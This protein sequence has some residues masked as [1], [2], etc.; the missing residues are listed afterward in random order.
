[1]ATVSSNTLEVVVKST[2]AQAVAAQMRQVTTATKELGERVKSVSST[3]AGM[4]GG[5]AAGYLSGKSLLGFAEKAEEAAKSVRQFETALKSTGQSGAVAVL[6]GQAS[7]LSAEMKQSAGSI[8]EVQKVLLELGLQAQTVAKYTPAVLDVA[9]GLG[10]DPATVAAQ[11]GRALSG[12]LGGLS[13]LG[14][15]A[16]TIKELD[17][18]LTR[19]EG[20]AKASATATDALNLAMGKIG[21]TLGD[22]INEGGLD[23]FKGKLAEGLEAVGKSLKKYLAEHKAFIEWLREMGGSL[24]EKAA[25]NLGK[26]ALALAAVSVSITALTAGGALI[27]LAQFYASLPLV[28][29]SL[30]LLTAGGRTFLTVFS[31]MAAVVGPG[32][33]AN[34]KAVTV[35]VGALRVALVGLGSAVAAVAVAW[36]GWNIGKKISEFKVAGVEIA[37]W[38][39]DTHLRSR[40]FWAHFFGFISDKAYEERK[41]RLK[42]QFDGLKELVKEGAEGVA[43]AVAEPTELGRVLITG[44][45]REFEDVMQDMQRMEIAYGRQMLAA[46]NLGD[47]TRAT[48]DALDDRIGKLTE[49]EEL[50][51]RDMALAQEAF[52][53]RR[54]MQRT[55]ESAEAFRE[56]DR[57]AI[58]AFYEAEKKFAERML[59]L[60]GDRLK[61]E[62]DRA[63]LRRE[64]AN[65]TYAGSTAE[66]FKAFGREK[67]AEGIAGTGGVGPGALAGVQNSMIQ[68]GT[69]ASQVGNAIQSSIGGVVNSLSDAFEGLILRTLT[70]KDALLQVG[71]AIVASVVKAFAQMAAQMLVSFILQKI[72]GQAVK[73]QAQELAIAWGPASVAASIATY[74]TAAAVGTAAVISAAGIGTAALA[75]MT[76]AKSGGYTG[77]GSADAIA[78]FYHGQEFVFSAPVTAHLGRE[79]L[80]ALHRGDATISRAGGQTA[81]APISVGVFDSR[82]E[83]EA[84]LRSG[85]G[86]AVVLDVFRRHRH[87]F[88]G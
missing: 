15:H 67:E 52:D 71:R 23:A 16:K 49:A 43:A 30:A 11:L 4:V 81:A 69:T 50:A 5:F 58:K 1:M 36:A 60:D 17:E 7:E 10:K 87:E 24:G 29:G 44:R 33:V 45:P 28:A 19:F 34:L 68:L 38:I 9:A 8:R 63:A 77:D 37:D 59:Q 54:V 2:G 21:K 32:M 27:K 83:T 48:N 73:K 70:W 65:M 46:Q 14:I 75:G 86:R 25:A 53:K 82:S 13:R 6:S 18:A 78:G 40:N 35:E 26:V 76:M 51:R 80:E 64:I 20:Q 22:A 42:E 61:I 39:A 84:W 12:E 88:L 41:Q 72:F 85:P 66:R 57:E 79:D 56:Q 62:Q 74:G 47:E 3:L 55:H 31:Q